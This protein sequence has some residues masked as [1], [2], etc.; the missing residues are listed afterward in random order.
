VGDKILTSH[1]PGFFLSA[2]VFPQYPAGKVDRLLFPGQQVTDFLQ[3][4]FEQTGYLFRLEMEGGKRVTALIQMDV[5]VLPID[6]P[7]VQI[8]LLRPDTEGDQFIGIDTKAQL[9]LQFPHT[10]PRLLT[11]NDVTGCGHIEA[12]RVGDA[13]GVSELK[14][15]ANRS[16]LPAKE[17]TVKGLVP[18]SFLMDLLPIG[19]ADDI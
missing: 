12:I 15:E 1:P 10:V 16:L 8:H 2:P 13:M 9:F 6:P 19:G 5:T 14:Q 3:I 7:L 11:V 17:P 18:K 4:R